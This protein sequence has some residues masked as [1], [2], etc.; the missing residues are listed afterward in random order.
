MH[1]MQ[2]LASIIVVVKLLIEFRNEPLKNNARKLIVVAKGGGDQDTL[3]AFKDKG[4]GKKDEIPKKISCFPYK[5]PHR[6]FKC[7]KWGKLAALIQE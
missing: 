4:K 7:P 6:V 1:G 5:G 3:T 2:D